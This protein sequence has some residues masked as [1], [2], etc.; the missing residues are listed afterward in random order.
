VP[1]YTEKWYEKP[2]MTVVNT[3]DIRT[4][5]ELITDL[6]CHCCTRMLGVLV[7][8]WLLW[9][10]VTSFINRKT[11]QPSKRQVLQMQS[12]L[13]DILFLSTS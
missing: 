8:L 10:V 3:T 12:V 13:I 11:E 4:L 5:Y 1:G 6:L 2:V 9:K 7:S